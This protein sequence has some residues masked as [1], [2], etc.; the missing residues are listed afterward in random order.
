MQA[1]GSDGAE[2][3]DRE[4]QVPGR[5]NSEKGGRVPPQLTS[6]WL[7]PAPYPMNK[8]KAGLSMTEPVWNYSWPHTT[9]EVEML[10]RK[11]RVS[12]RPEGALNATMD[13]YEYKSGFFWV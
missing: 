3:N 8:E 4:V 12:R 13:P 9:S 1:V 6:A 7:S 10:M 11:G 2:W 5:L